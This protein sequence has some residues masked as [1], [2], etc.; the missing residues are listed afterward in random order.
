MNADAGQGPPPGGRPV[1]ATP[2]SGQERPP[3][4][5]DLRLVPAALA[6]WATAAVAVGWETEGQWR[7]V[8]G[9]GV[10]V[11]L[12]AGGLLPVLRGWHPPRHRA[13]LRPGATGAHGARGSVVASALLCLV[14]VAATLGVT[15]A[16]LAVRERD[17]LTVAVRQDRT[18][19]L[20]GTV[21]SAP[22]LLGEQWGEELW[23]V[24]LDVDAVDGSA[25]DAAAVVL[26]A[27]PW[28]QV[29]MGE[30]VRVRT[31]PRPTERGSREVAFVGAAAGVRVLA[32]PQGV[33]GTVAGLRAGL[34]QAVGPEPA[35]GSSCTGGPVGAASSAPTDVAPGTVRFQDQDGRCGTEETTG[36]SGSPSPS[37]WPPGSHALVPGVALGD[38]SALPGQVREDMR[39]VS[40]THLTAVSGQHV[41]IV[42]G[43]TLGALGA[44][45]RRWR[46]LIG[47]GVLVLLVVLVRPGGSVVRAA[48]MGTVV[49]A[50]V[51]AGRRSVSLPALCTA[52]TSLV[53]LDPW[54][55]RDYGFALSVCATA[56]IL[57]GTRPLQAVLG[58]WLPPW[59]AAA[60][61]LPVVAQAACLPVL[62][63]LQPGLG[64][65]AVV[66]NVVAA[67]VVPVAT[68]AGLA[69]ALLAPLWP[70]LA[71]VVAWPALVCCAWLAGVARVT[72]GLPGATL[73]WPGGVGGAALMALVELAAVLLV[74]GW[75]RGRRR[76]RAP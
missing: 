63:M 2:G 71:G 49:L 30:R 22:R 19:T 45:P 14:G 8:L 26:G 38:D 46:A 68:V 52:V 40:M 6:V 60:L 35:A 73:P 36:E 57:L 55:S 50:G 7:A 29:S 69:A 33:L 16:H 24:A 72:A 67:P 74:H 10:L 11:L 54:Q 64:P 13:D 56:G 3:E 58:R 76:T 61:A 31:R 53:L 51:A 20:V 65:W 21:A 12:A 1:S 34:V 42:L 37:R 25:S 17:P 43:L 62:L 47:A 5:L 28:G 15:A 4:A 27:Q 75:A 9:A 44:V 70:A 59:L 41:A 48:A 18:V 32:P 66:A 39:T 23:L